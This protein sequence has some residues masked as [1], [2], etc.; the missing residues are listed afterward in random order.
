MRK[1][2][3]KRIKE[4]KEKKITKQ[5][6]QKDEPYHKRCFFADRPH[7]PIWEKVEWMS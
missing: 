4:K 2:D 7:K 1:E 3:E 6:K 5:N